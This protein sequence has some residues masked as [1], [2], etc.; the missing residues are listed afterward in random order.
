M[1]RWSI[2]YL[3]AAK[4][5]W[6]QTLMANSPYSVAWIMLFQNSVPEFS[7]LITFFLPYTKEHSACC[8]PPFPTEIE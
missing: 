6:I 3:A 2:S 7:S 5:L 4:P 1:V 8:P